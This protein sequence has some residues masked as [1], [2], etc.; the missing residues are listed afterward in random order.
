MVFQ[1]FTAPA[2]SMAHGQ[3]C[4]LI[5]NQQSSHYTYFALNKC[6]QSSRVTHAKSA[7]LDCDLSNLSLPVPL[8]NQGMQTQSYS[9][10]KYYLLT[11]LIIGNWEFASLTPFAFLNLGPFSTH[12]KTVLSTTDALVKTGSIRKPE[13]THICGPGTAIFRQAQAR[14]GL[15][16]TGPS[17]DHCS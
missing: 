11:F 9:K 2:L 6:S 17:K 4:M 3:S 8:W 10:Q 13:P 7:R 12:S 14:F 16:S 5:R 15:G 1:I